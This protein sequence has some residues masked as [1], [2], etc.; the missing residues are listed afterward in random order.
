MKRFFIVSICTL[1]LIIGIYLWNSDTFKSSQLPLDDEQTN[2]EEQVVINFSHVVAENT[3]KGVAAKKFAELVKEKTG[4]KI[5]IQ[6]YPNGI[7]YN[8]ETEMD[9]LKD[10]KVQIIAPTFSKMSSLVPSWEVLDLPFLIETDEQLETVL[11]SDLKDKLLKDLEKHHI[12]GLDFWSNGFKQIAANQ[13][14][15]ETDDFKALHIRVM[16]SDLLL[17][18]MQLLGA[19]PVVSDFDSVFN[20]MKSDK[21]NA[22][23][24]TISNIYSKGFHT[25]EKHITLSNHGIMGYSIL[26]N[27]DFWK[28]LKPEYQKAIEESLQEMKEWQIEQ[29][30]LINESSLK[31]LD[32]IADVQIKTPTKEQIDK[33]K[34]K[35]EPLYDEYQNE[36]YEEYY[37]LLMELLKS[38]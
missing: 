8:D 9:A 12:K 18:Q 27:E 33:W 24:N 16:N 31:A 14:V 23:E 29:S 38:K 28:D 13:Q 30:K 22:Q 6:V 21:I 2:L 37:D 35:V 5:I 17:E 20:M 32:S 3:P 25:Y 10:N 1:C 19:T 11:N 36:G 15:L 34:E 7:L 4:G 26:M